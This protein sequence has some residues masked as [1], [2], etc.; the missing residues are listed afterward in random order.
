MVHVD[1]ARKREK[2]QSMYCAF[3]KAV[4]SYKEG[5]VR[6]RFLEF[7]GVIIDIEGRVERG[8]WGHPNF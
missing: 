5:Q 7:V 3:A 8:P 4:K 6:G 1:S 2:P